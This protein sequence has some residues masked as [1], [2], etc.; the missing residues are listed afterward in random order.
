MKPDKMAYI[1][2]SDLE[3]LSKKTDGCAKNPEKSSAAKLVNMLVVDIQYRLQE[4][5]LYCRKH[6]M[7]NFCEYLREQRKNEIN[8]EKKKKCYR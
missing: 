3:S 2:Y 4:H 6:C 5:S 7:K 8:S 1:I